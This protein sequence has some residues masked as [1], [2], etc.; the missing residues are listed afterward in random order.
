MRIPQQQL[1]QGQQTR[2]ER[3]AACKLADRLLANALRRQ[4]G[5]Q[6]RLQK[7]F[8]PCTRSRLRRHY[9][10]L[11]AAVAHRKAVAN[12]LSFFVD[13]LLLRMPTLTFSQMQRQQHQ[14]PK[15]SHRVQSVTSPGQL[16]H[17]HRNRGG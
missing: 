16:Q 10:K 3:L 2:D 15:Q 4:V 17:A 7:T 14:A 1:H 5:C 6:Q 12:Q 11:C 8:W 9:A 13:L